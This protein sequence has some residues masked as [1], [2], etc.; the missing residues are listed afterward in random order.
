MVG[1]AYGAL[2]PRFDEEDTQ[3]V[4]RQRFSLQVYR[5]PEVHLAKHWGG[6]VGLFALPSLIWPMC[7]PLRHLP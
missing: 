3:Q 6:G 2:K 7:Q 5:T 1:G 4:R